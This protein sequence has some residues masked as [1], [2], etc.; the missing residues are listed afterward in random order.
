MINDK[1]NRWGKIL[2][3]VLLFAAYLLIYLILR[4]GRKELLNETGIVVIRFLPFLLLVIIVTTF[5]FYLMTKTRFKDF[6]KNHPVI[7]L[8]FLVTIALCEVFCFS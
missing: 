4:L 1:V 3:S 7:I 2:S 8:V 6:E 5:I